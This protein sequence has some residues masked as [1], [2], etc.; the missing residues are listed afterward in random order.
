MS[1]CDL[2][3]FNMFESP[4]YFLFGTVV[5]HHKNKLRINLHDW[6]P[7][8]SNTLC[9]CKNWTLSNH[10]SINVHVKKLPK[11]KD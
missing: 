2:S 7:K 5:D 8:I 9:T 10:Q 1:K 3:G 6:A 4:N 11:N